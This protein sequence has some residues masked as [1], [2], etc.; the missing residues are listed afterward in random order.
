MKI[1]VVDNNEIVLGICS[2]V[3]EKLGHTVESAVTGYEALKKLSE[4][5]YD[6]LFIELFLTDMSGISLLEKIKDQ[7]IVSIILTNFH[8]V[9]LI[10]RAVE[11]GASSYLFKPIDPD[12]LEATLAMCEKQHEIEQNRMEAKQ[13][14]LDSQQK[15]KTLVDLVT[16][17]IVIVQ[18]GI[19]RFINK[20]MADMLGLKLARVINRNMKDTFVVD[21]AERV[22]QRMV[23]FIENG[24]PLEGNFGFRDHNGREFT[25][26]LIGRKM[27]YQNQPA[28]M[29]VFQ[30][31]TERVEMN[32]KIT[33]I[34][35]RYRVLHENATDA[36]FL[37]HQ[38][39]SIQDTNR[40]A[41]L[42]SG[43]SK[44]DLTKMNIKDI[45]PEE[46]KDRFSFI[47]NELRNLGGIPPSELHLRK[48]NGSALPVEMSAVFIDH[49]SYLIV[50]CDLSFDKREAERTHDFEHMY[51]ML[52]N[53]IH[54]YSYRMLE[55]GKFL[56]LDDKIEEITFYSKE[57]FLNNKISWY[58]IVHDEDRERVVEEHKQQK[59]GN[60]INIE[61][62][63]I[64][65]SGKIHWVEE[66]RCSCNEHPQLS[67]ICFCGLITD[68]TEDHE[69]EDRFTNMGIHY[70]NIINHIPAVVYAMTYSDNFQIKFVSEYLQTLLGYSPDEVMQQPENIFMDNIHEADKPQILKIMEKYFHN[71]G[72]DF[73]L[74]YRI[75]DKFKNIRTI[76]NRG[77]MRKNSQG[78]Y[79]IDG[80]LYDHSLT[81]S[82][83]EPVRIPV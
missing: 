65:K 32:K 1:L 48:R 41:E 78:S 19:I 82:L 34:E 83:P 43:Y 54:G 58:S 67:E 7:N 22:Y 53:N 30:D 50:V 59:L 38:N 47:F 21:G 51:H 18:N 20:S 74:E 61:Y 23:R 13:K 17:G 44:N 5:K 10:R 73:I 24:T 33:K 12:H 39:G 55:S 31:I 80:T 75:Y 62:R 60:N 52:R 63:I 15:Y 46:E 6:F 14:L 64:D 16:E 37:I 27:N 9:D 4:T 25:I 66:K 45:I 56:F 36:F 11:L 70:Q 77:K 68:K 8:S 49:E 40:K 71:G 76:V 81:R 42:L 3:F 29:F 35:D 69:R 72:G 26:F 2:L 28:D 79:E 57:E